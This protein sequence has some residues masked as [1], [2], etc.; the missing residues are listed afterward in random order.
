MGHMKELDIRIRQG[1]D[2]AIAAAC[3]LAGITKE[4]RA[5]D[6]VNSTAS[7]ITDIVVVLRSVGFAAVPPSAGDS[8]SLLHY[9]VTHAADEI[10]RL[11][12]EQRWIP[13]EERLPEQECRCLLV[14]RGEVLMSAT[15]YPPGKFQPGITHWMPLPSPPE[16]TT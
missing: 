3:E 6:A 10:E 5:Y 15:Y 1:G 12:E 16:V 8:A 14:I 7:E 11:R 13:V 4:R 2:D 9:C